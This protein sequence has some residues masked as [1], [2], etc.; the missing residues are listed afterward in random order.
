MLN[1][2]VRVVL[3][4]ALLSISALAVEAQEA[5]GL[6]VSAGLA[7]PTGDLSDAEAGLGFQIGGQYSMPL[8]GALGLRFNADYTRFGIDVSGVDGS[9]TN[10]GGMAN[11]VYNLST[12]TGFKP[13][14]LGG[15]GYGN[16]TVDI[17]GFGSDSEAGVAFNL[18]AGY[19]FDMGG[20]KWFAEIRYVSQDAGG[21]AVTYLPIVIGLRF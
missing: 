14:L 9:Y 17:D 20:R 15:V 11:L 8:Q 21:D 16:F 2:S 1:R 6:G 19:N 5:K 18:G 13:Y 4:A 10:I 12:G 7:L 3:G